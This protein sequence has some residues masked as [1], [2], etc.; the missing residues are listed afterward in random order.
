[1][2]CV[3]D[4][5]FLVGRRGSGGASL[6]E[7]ASKPKVTLDWFGTVEGFEGVVAC[8]DE[9]SEMVMGK[10]EEQ[11]LWKM[12]VGTSKLLGCEVRSASLDA[13]LLPMAQRKR[14]RSLFCWMR[15]CLT[16]MP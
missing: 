2:I 8:S 13:F 6:G 5:L 14:K 11:W 4:H 16:G 1:M 9:F 3:V 12:R 15:G 10:I 7:L